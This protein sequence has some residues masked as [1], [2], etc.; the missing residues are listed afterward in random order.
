MYQAS[1][2]MFISYLYGCLRKYK[3][4]KVGFDKRECYF[5]SM[6]RGFVQ[7]KDLA[8]YRITYV[9]LHIGLLCFLCACGKTILSRQDVNIC[10]MFYSNEL[11]FSVCNWEDYA[12]CLCSLPIIHIQEP[13]YVNHKYLTNLSFKLLIQNFHVKLRYIYIEIFFLT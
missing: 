7:F 4:K 9:P 1:Q 5:I 12:H 8:Y 3:G 11:F 6:S 10:M 2:D 13:K